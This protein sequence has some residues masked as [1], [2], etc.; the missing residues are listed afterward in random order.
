[1]P[2]E[3]SQLRHFCA[4]QINSTSVSLSDAFCASVCMCLLSL[5][6]FVRSHCDLSVV[7]QETHTMEPSLWPEYFESVKSPVFGC[8][9]SV[10]QENKLVGHRA[11]LL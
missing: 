9:V 11:S 4:L 6:S 1:M 3:A 10:S 5:Q 2:E 7:V 8:N